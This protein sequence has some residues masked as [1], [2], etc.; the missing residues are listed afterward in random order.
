LEEKIKQQINNWYY[1]YSNDIFRYAYF[2]IGDRD[3]AKDILQ[4]TF[5]RA[6]HHF[7]SFE[8]ENV[9][10]WLFRIARNL[11]IDYFRKKKPIAYYLDYFVSLKGTMKTPEEITMMNETERQLY[12]ALTKIKRTY[13]DVII[14]RKIK[15]FST[16]DTAKILGWTESKVK[17][18]LLRGMKILKKVLEEEGYYDGKL[19]SRCE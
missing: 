7:D 11:S 1:E 14:L 8:G 9:R 13:R 12:T 6:Y 18:N 5:L 2:L 16:T 3:Q 4:D 15:E 19:Y 17:V 10:G